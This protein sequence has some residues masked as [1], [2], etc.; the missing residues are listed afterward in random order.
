V[1]VIIASVAL[2]AAKLTE[3]SAES[4]SSHRPAFRRWPLLR[5]SSQLALR[6]MRVRVPVVSI[7]DEGPE[8]FVLK[9]PVRDRGIRAKIQIQ[10]SGK[11]VGAKSLRGIC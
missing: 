9:S 1:K 3:L 2:I 4:H 8:P 5:E 11:A 6:A 7:A 10:S